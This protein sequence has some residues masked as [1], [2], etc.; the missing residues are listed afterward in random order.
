MDLNLAQK[1]ISLAI[2]GKWD[3]ALELNKEIFK[4]NPNDIDCINRIARAYAELGDLKNARTYAKKAIKLDPF[5]NIAIKSLDKWRSLKQGDMLKTTVSS[6]EAFLEEPGKTKIVSLMHV[7]NSDIL[8]KL[9]SG[10]ELQINTHGH[11]ITITSSD[12][13]YIGKLPDDLSAHLRNLIKFGNKYK[14]IV[15][16]INKSDIKVIIRETKKSEK[17]KD[18]PSFSPE[19]IDYISFTPPELVHNK[20]AIVNSDIDDDE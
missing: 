3:I 5:N 9:D 14:C 13:K 6:A 12:G 10:D 8:A 11:R 18:I 17:L 20:P 1:A 19:K 2:S 16:A 15:K 4:K 7:G